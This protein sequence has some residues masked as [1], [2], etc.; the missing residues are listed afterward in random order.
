L[1]FL[2]DRLYFRAHKETQVDRLYIGDALLSRVSGIDV[3]NLSRRLSD[4]NGTF[5]GIVLVSVA[6]DSFTANYEP[7]ILGK[8]GLLGVTSQDRSWSLARIGDRV[9]SPEQSKFLT[10]VNARFRS[11]SGSAKFD[12]KPWFSD[13]RG[14]FVGWH[15]IQGYPLV[16]VVGL[17]EHEKLA[18]V[19]VGRKS[20]I[21]YAL[22]ATAA[23][24]VITLIAIALTAELAWKNHR[25]NLTHATYRLATE[26]ASEGF[27][28]LS[29]LRNA[30]G[31]VEDFLILDCNTQGAEFLNRRRH[32][33]VGMSA[34]MLYG[35]VDMLSL[36]NHLSEAL[37]K[38]VYENEV[39]VP[40]R[41][42]LKVR[43]VHVK[44]LRSGENL[45]VRLRDI[46]EIKAHLA[47]LKRRGDEDVLTSLPNRQWILN[48][49]PD[50]LDRARNCNQRLALLFI[51]L[52]GFKKV[53]DTAGH[54]AG[55]KVLQHVAQRLLVAVRPHDKVVRFGGDEFVLILEQMEERVDAAH[56]AERIQHAFKQPFEVSNSVYILGTSIG[57]A[58]FPGDGEDA[59]GLLEK[60]DIAMY[61][62]KT[63][64]KGGYQFYQA[65]FYNAL[66]ERIDKE[67]ELRNAIARD[68]FVIHYQPRVDI[69]TGMT[70]SLEALVR[71]QHPLKG[72]LP[73]SEFIDLAEET[74][75]VVGIGEL[76]IKRVCAQL[77]QWGTSGSGLIPVSINVSPKQFSGKDI[78][79]LLNS[80]LKRYEVSAGLVELEVTESCVIVDSDSVMKILSRLQK[81]GVKILVD[82][83]GTGYSSLSQLYKMDFDVLKV[84]QIFTAELD[85]SDEARIFFTAIIT[86]A[87]SLGMRVVAEGVETQ[88]QA[89][90]L[91]ALQCDEMQGFFISR[92]LPPEKEQWFSKKTKTNLRFQDQVSS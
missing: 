74:G 54:A 77:A 70:S 90:I 7:T 15:P 42:P 84:D 4:N 92:P 20:T 72:L 31:F 23:F 21:R 91:G 12:G 76:V 28:I 18:Q 73:P 29:P 13:E 2:G 16:A 44:I 65:K 39:E 53:N 37:E 64:G 47:E 50:A 67:T 89:E 86:M 56:V 6:I 17:D 26:E 11:A 45:A 32:E 61:S 62:V 9:L 5:D 57:I 51:D 83:F 30:K 24:A 34:S 25:L 46:S 3:V 85:K 8:N 49:L 81:Q 22:G 35:H 48:Y 69:A 75:L 88:R 71:W 78:G 43:H 55:D 82:D 68:E 52:D 27:Y 63:H 14:R 66:R 87:H 33:L 38:G 36:K 41:S 10:A 1:V 19:W 59:A 60:A 80:T 58:L 79:E 40:P